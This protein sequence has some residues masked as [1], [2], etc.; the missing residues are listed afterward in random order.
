MLNASSS[1]KN[2]TIVRSQKSLR[3]A[4]AALQTFTQLEGEWNSIARQKDETLRQIEAL[5][6]PS[7]SIDSR[8]ERSCSNSSSRP[9]S[10][11][12]SA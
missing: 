12:R 1:P 3:L 9:L 5:E 10:L 2:R 6:R 11:V 4:K 8:V 7:S